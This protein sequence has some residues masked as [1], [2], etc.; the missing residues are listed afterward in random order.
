MRLSRSVFGLNRVPTLDSTNTTNRLSHIGLVSFRLGF[1]VSLGFGLDRGVMR[2]SR[3]VFDLNG[4]LTL[5]STNTTNRLGVGVIALSFF[6]L[7]GYSRREQFGFG[8]GV[9]V[10]VRIVVRFQIFRV[11][12][13]VLIRGTG[14]FI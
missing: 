6:S 2:L 1:R 5:D 10:D 8:G 4:V 3:S 12:V 14:V 11:D 13:E 7:S 9:L